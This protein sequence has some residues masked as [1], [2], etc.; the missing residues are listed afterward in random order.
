MR[1]TH[2]EVQTNRGEVYYFKDVLKESGNIV[3]IPK[4]F[5]LASVCLKLTELMY[6]I[7]FILDKLYIDGYSRI[8]PLHSLPNN[9]RS[10]AP[11]VDDIKVLRNNNVRL[12]ELSLSSCPYALVSVKG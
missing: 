6:C 1:G 2:S 10:K 4:Q 9:L 8:L 7:C 3:G 11:S 5:L 12:Q